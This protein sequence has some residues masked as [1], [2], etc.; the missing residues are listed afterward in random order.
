[1][2][3]TELHNDGTSLGEKNARVAKLGHDNGKITLTGAEQGN[4]HWLIQ[5]TSVGLKKVD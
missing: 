5:T 2:G 4:E 3:R 1:M